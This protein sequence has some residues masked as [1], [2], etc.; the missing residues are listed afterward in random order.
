MDSQ[1][2]K[3]TEPASAGADD[4]K[5]QVAKDFKKLTSAQQAKILKE[6]NPEALAKIDKE[7]AERTA[8]YRTIMNWLTAILA[9]GGIYYLFLR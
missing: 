5:A 8:K 6:R 2:P 3:K 4:R 7:I 9:A 1:D